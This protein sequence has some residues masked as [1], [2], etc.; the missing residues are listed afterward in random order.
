[1]S[2]FLEK[3]KRVEGLF[4]SL[5]FLVDVQA[6]DTQLAMY[7]FAKHEEAKKAFMS[8]GNLGNIAGKPAFD[9]IHEV[10]LSQYKGAEYHDW[11]HTCCMIVNCASGLRFLFEEEAKKPFDERKYTITKEIFNTVLLAAAFH[12]IGHTGG[13]ESDAY[14]VS[15]AVTIATEFYRAARFTERMVDKDLM[16]RLIQVTQFP[17]VHKPATDYEMIIRDA[18]LLQ[19]LE[20]TWFEVIY[21]NLYKEISRS[22]ANISFAQFCQ[23]QKDFLQKAEFHSWWFQ[24]K[25]FEQFKEALQIVE[26]LADMTK[27]KENGPS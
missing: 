22:R 9:A 6:Y 8:E 1:M 26:K 13:R 21:K 24:C 20:P 4:T 15:R 27:E 3:K 19:I 17:F 18:D 12:D 25:K 10:F 2:D 11:Y 5:D 7:K 23:G 16:I 14:N